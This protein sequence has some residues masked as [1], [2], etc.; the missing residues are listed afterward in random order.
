M[1]NTKELLHHM[2]PGSSDSNLVVALANEGVLR[3]DQ[4]HN[5]TVQTQSL[6]ENQNQNHTNKQLL[7]LA[8]RTDTGITDNSNRH[9]SRKTRQ[10]T[11]K[12]GRQMRKAS[13]QRILAQAVLWT[14]DRSLNN[15]RNN[16]TVDAQ[17]T[18]HDHRND[19]PHHQTGIHHAHRRDADARLGRTVG[20]ADVGKDQGAGNA[21]E[22]EEGGAG[23][24]GFHFDAHGCAVFCVTL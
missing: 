23:G 12:T 19:V 5:Q 13:V 17:H 8:D 16:Q 4:G 3:E 7:L 2:T 14:N 21:H 11:A 1:H 6:G 18:R 24:A 22:P 20:G 10:S 9:T 15:H